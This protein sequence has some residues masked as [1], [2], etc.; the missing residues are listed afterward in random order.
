MWGQSYFEYLV[1]DMI[2][3]LTQADIQAVIAA[4]QSG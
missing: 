2:P 4:R 3:S 1:K